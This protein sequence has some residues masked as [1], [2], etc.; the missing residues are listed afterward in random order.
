MNLGKTIFAQV[1]EYLPKHEFHR[2]V[3]RYDGSYKVQ[4]FS[5]YDH[6]L[7]MAFT[8]LT[9]RESLRDTVTCLYAH[10]SKLYQMGFRGRVVR[11][12]LSHAN[13][14]RSWRIYAD[15]ARVLIQQAHESSRD[16]PFAAELSNTV[17]A[18]YS[19]TNHIHHIKHRQIHRH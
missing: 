12:T 2:F 11:S 13:N 9:Y 3:E 4:Q 7:C 14:T 1:M 17:Y 16:E 15:F 6:F 5:C 19:T 18:S 8:Q 10:Q